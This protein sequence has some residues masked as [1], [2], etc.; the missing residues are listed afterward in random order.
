MKFG[1]NSIENFAA[2]EAVRLLDNFHSK[3]EEFFDPASAVNI[4]VANITT[5]LTMGKT[6]PYDDKE[7]LRLTQ[8]ADDTFDYF[9]TGAIYSL[10]PELSYLP[11]TGNR[12]G[13]EAI[14]EMFDFIRQSV[15]DHR[16]HFDPNPEPRDM[17][18]CFLLEQHER[19]SKGDIGVFD[20]TNMLQFTWDVLIGGWQTTNTTILWYLFILAQQTDAQHRVQAELDRVVGRDRLPALTDRASL[21]YVHAT[22]AECYRLSGLLPMQIPH[23]SRCDVTVGG[24]D[25]PRGSY[26]A[27]NTHFLCSSPT[28]WHEPEEFRPERFIDETGAFDRKREA[29]LVEFGVGRRACPGEQLSRTELFVLFSHIFHR[30]IIELHDDVPRTMEGTTGL[31]V[32][33]LPFK[34]CAIQRF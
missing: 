24:Y 25:V 19:R 7:F 11:S 31:T 33:P 13:E 23:R 15:G 14:A 12:K 6:F 29:G 34:I 27:S 26:V 16:K 1:P 8:L 2:E 28:L 4:A 32:N 20:D 22:M 9:G 10:V 30:F 17:V 21:P 18:E 5:R 3:D